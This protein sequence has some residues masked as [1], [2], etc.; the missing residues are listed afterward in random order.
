MEAGGAQI[1][2][3]LSG[4]LAANFGTEGLYYVKTGGKELMKAKDGSGLLGILKAENGGVGGGMARLIKLNGVNLDAVSAVNSAALSMT[5]I[6]MDIERKLDEIQDMQQEMLDAMKAKERADL[7]GNINTLTDILNNYKYNWDNEK[8]KTNKHILVQDIRRA[9]EQSIQFCS[10]Q[11]RK[12]LG[13]QT[14]AVSSDLDVKNRSEKIQ[15]TLKN[16]QMALYQYAF[17]AF[18]EV[19]L[20][21]N[22]AENYIKSIMDRI[23]DLT[24]TFREIYTD[25]YNLLEKMEK[26][27]VQSVLTE[28]LAGISKGAGQVIAKIPVISRGPVDEALIASAETIS[29]KKEKKTAEKMNRI[30]ELSGNCTTPFIE[31]LEEIREEHSG[32]KAIYFDRDNLYLVDE[33]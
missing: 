2:S 21:E 24:L 27:S 11:L 1:L 7:R 20:L 22:F 13:K 14:G 6:M 12:V 28:G 8:Y 23:S 16:Y 31:L 3:G 30:S 33:G 10:D 18:L 26:G 4:A 17:S 5:C 19:L 15:D 32:P 25:C 9:A 29:R